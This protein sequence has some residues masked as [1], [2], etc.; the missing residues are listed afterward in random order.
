M[1]VFAVMP[2]LA[3]VLVALLAVYGVLWSRW[4]AAGQEEGR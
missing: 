3:L 2:V 4:R 1:L